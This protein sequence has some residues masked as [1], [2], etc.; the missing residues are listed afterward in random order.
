MPKKNKAKKNT[1]KSASKA[2]VETT[3]RNGTTQDAKNS[4]SST[5]QKMNKTTNGKND[6]AQQIAIIVAVLLIPA[7]IIAYNYATQPSTETTKLENAFVNELTPTKVENNAEDVSNNEPLKLDGEIQA[8]GKPLIKTESK[9]M[10]VLKPNEGDEEKKNKENEQSEKLEET[11]EDANTIESAEPKESE[12]LE[13]KEESDENNHKI[14]KLAIVTKILQRLIG[15]MQS[16]QDT[17]QNTNEKTTSEQMANDEPKPEK[18]IESDT[19][20]D[21]ANSGE[22]SI[23]NEKETNTGTE[24]NINELNMLPNTSSKTRYTVKKGDNI[25]KI[26]LKVCENES[27]YKK[28]MQ[29]NYLKVGQTIEVECN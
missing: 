19:N 26:S 22:S 10:I 11:K 1:M 12:E 27:Y 29:D 3:N 5:Q 24:K 16:N 4:T 17:N 15:S 23:G 20:S 9:T 2:K 8:E 14:L 18:N 28:H 6:T 7:A 13:N 25:Y 21:K